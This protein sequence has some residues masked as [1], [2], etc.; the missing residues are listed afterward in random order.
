MKTILCIG[1]AGLLALL[2]AA[3]YGQADGAGAGRPAREVAG[4]PVV[5]FGDTLFWIY[6]GIGAIPVET[7]AGFIIENI[8]ALEGDPF[9]EADSL[10]VVAAAGSCDIVYAGK[11]IM[12]VF[13]AQATLLGYDIA[14]LADEYR[15]RIVTAIGAQR[16]DHFWGRLLKR[17]G[18]G[19]LLLAATWCS[20]KYLNSLFRYIRRRILN[21]KNK[22][23]KKL[24]YLFGADKQIKIATAL[25]NIIRFIL[26][27]VILYICLLLFFRLFPST[28][29]LSDT[30]T[31]YLWLPL[32]SA[33]IATRD[34][35]PNLFAIIVIVAIFLGLIR[36]VRYVAGRIGSG[37]ITIK[38]FYPDWASSTFNIVRIILLVFMFVMI[39]P[40]LPNYNS[41]V[42]QGV[43]V[44]IGL[45]LSLGST[46]LIGN[47]IAGLV[48]TY[49]R[50][51]KVGDRI[52]MGDN[53]GNVIEKNSLVTRIRTVKNEVITIPNATIMAS[54]TINYT[55]S[56]EAYG[57]ILHAVVTMGY[58]I[59]WRRMHELLI[60]AGQK[61]IHVLND[62]KPFVNQIALDDFYVQY[63]INI[64]TQNADAMTA[65]YA[66]LNQNIQDIF[67]REGIELLAPHIYAHRGTGGV[68]IPKDFVKP[69]TAKAPAFDVNVQGIKA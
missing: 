10:K 12:S 19:M 52:K 8:R 54:Q 60:E 21:K 47:L 7:R 9:Y 4:A 42:F 44:F 63:E 3:S 62:P 18:L 1:F 17:I 2:P 14:H 56:A 13:D 6:G 57:L 41:K 67:N 20:I 49:M 15:H 59:A 31:G 64:Y 30:L 51:F 5:P 66:D 23:V 25:L 26:V 33:A 46:S 29:W 68:A 35:I 45:L 34:Y 61:T 16:A 11:V 28:R 43:S 27:A 38:G 55:H 40:H 48:I 37:A 65:I 24:Y 58:E 36:A 32:K 39:F 53:L 69:A 22:T 50:P